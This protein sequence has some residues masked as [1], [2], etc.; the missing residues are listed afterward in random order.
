MPESTELVIQFP[1][2]FNISLLVASA[3]LYAEFCLYQILFKDQK[4]SF[5]DDKVYFYYSSEN[6]KQGTLKKFPLHC[7]FWT[8][9][10]SKFKINIHFK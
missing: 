1:C 3:S 5:T 9:L 2:L 7:S 10:F 8:F 4:L 6:N